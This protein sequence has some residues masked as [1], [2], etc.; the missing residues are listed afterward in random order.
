MKFTALGDRSKIMIIAKREM[1]ME[2]LGK[3]EKEEKKKGEE[4]RKNCTRAC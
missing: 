3:V 2:G 1:V 4:D